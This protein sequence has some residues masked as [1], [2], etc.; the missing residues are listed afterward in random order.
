MTFRPKFAN[1]NFKKISLDNFLKKYSKDNP[2]MDSK[3]LRKDLIN[4]RQLKN[5]GVKCNCGNDLWIIGSAISGKGCFSC[6]TMSAD[7]SDDFEIE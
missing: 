5:D 1:S 6:I 2:G 3:Q 7:C 4:F